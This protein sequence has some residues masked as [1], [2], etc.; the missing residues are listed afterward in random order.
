MV[1]VRL[2]RIVRAERAR[3]RERERKRV[4]VREERMRIVKKVVEG[5]EERGRARGDWTDGAATVVEADV[6]WSDDEDEEFK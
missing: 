3:S 1:K 5:E 6:D 2:K 4:G